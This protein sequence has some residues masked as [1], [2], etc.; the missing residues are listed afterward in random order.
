MI[1]WKLIKYSFLISMFAC[2]AFIG[3][4][5]IGLFYALSNAGAVYG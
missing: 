5:A 3:I 4:M 1:L 2:V